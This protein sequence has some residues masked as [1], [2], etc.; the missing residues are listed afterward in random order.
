MGT[1]KKS[2]SFD[3]EQ[4][5]QCAASSLYGDAVN[6]L[7]GIVIVPVHIW[8][9]CQMSTDHPKRRIAMCAVVFMLIPLFFFLPA[10]YFQSIWCSRIGFLACIFLNTFVNLVEWPHEG[11]CTIT[12]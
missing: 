12:P 5:V 6:F 11:E 7:I 8:M 9:V 10:I 3:I 4:Q 1:P 2:E